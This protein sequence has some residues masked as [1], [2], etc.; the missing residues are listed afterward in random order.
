[1]TQPEL[2]K[3]MDAMIAGQYRTLGIDPNDP[4]GIQSTQEQ[5]ELVQ[6]RLVAEIDARAESDPEF[7]DAYLLDAAKQAIDKALAD[8]RPSGKYREDGS[9]PLSDTMRVQMP[10]ATRGHLLAW[11][12]L[13][14]DERNLGYIKSRL[15]LFDVHPECKNLAELEAV[16]RSSDT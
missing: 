11:A 16:I 8:K 2:E 15:D 13:E 1:M 7:M 9:I 4:H 14:S 12:L 5:D 6:R 10:W 3:Q